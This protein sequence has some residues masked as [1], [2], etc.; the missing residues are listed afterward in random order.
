ML[1]YVN[2]LNLV[3]LCIKHKV[4][5]IK[6][7]KTKKTTK[8]LYILLKFNIIYGWTM[9]QNKNWLGY[10]VYCN[11]NITNIH[12]FIKPSQKFFIKFKSIKIINA[13]YSNPSIF[14]ST[15]K[16]ILSLNEAFIKKT[17]GFLFFRV[18]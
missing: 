13:R 9:Y 7:P 2:T 16:G 6:I 8:L 3:R 10:F 17:G 11:T 1:P 18:L 15:P 4:K 12:T 5:Y 14:L